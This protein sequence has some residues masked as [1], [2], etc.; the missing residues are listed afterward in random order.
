MQ[1]REMLFFNET[2]AP[3]GKMQTWERVF[4]TNPKGTCRHGKRIYLKINVRVVGWV[5]GGKGVGPIDATDSIAV[6][7]IVYR[8]YRS[9]RFNRFN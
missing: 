6:T 7:S 2:R 4:L 3:V 1:T 9:Y 8:N 5:S